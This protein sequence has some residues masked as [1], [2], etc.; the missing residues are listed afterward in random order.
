MMIPISKLRI[1]VVSCLH[2][3]LYN[4]TVYLRTRY[5]SEF[6]MFEK[7]LI[8]INTKSVHEIMSFG[9]KKE[10]GGKRQPVYMPKL[11]CFGCN[12]RI[13]HVLI[14]SSEAAK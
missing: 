2:C 7:L 12:A 3:K 14:K 5:I 10:G 4:K 13:H 9:C 11:M 8:D 1:E 6:G